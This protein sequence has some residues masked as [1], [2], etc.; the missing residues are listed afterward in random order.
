MPHIDQMQH[1]RRTSRCEQ[2]DQRMDPAEVVEVNDDH[3]PDT[4]ADEFRQAHPS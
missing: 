2:A 1:R 4:S 3:E